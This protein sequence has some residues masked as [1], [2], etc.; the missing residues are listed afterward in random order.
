MIRVAFYE[1]AFARDPKNATL[2]W[3][4]LVEKL[5]SFRFSAKSLCS[6][7]PCTGRDSKGKL[8]AGKNGD[9]WS[10]VEI[11]GTRSNDNVR[12]VTVGVFDVDHPPDE[13]WIGRLEASGVEFVIHSTHQYPHEDRFRVA[14]PLSRKVSPDEWHQVHAAMMQALGLPADPLKDLSR[15]YFLPNAIEGVEPFS[16]HQPGHVLDVDKI[17]RPSPVTA[18][19]TAF[20]EPAPIDVN[21]LAASIRKHVKPENRMLV[22]RALRGEGLGPRARDGG[23]EYGG[24][25]NAL[26]ALMSTAAF[27]TDAAW[28]PIE[29]IFRPCFAATDWGE[30]FD[31]LIAVAK[32]K[33]ERARERKAKRDAQR[34]A[35][36]D[37]MWEA[38]GIIRAQRGERTTPLDE[39]VTDDP[40]RWGEKL[41]YTKE[42]TPKLA[43][44][45]ANVLRVLR[46]APEWKDAIRFNLVSKKLELRNA[47]DAI[48]SVDSLDVTIS[49]WFAES[50][51]GRLGLQPTPRMVGEALRAIPERMNY[52][53]LREYLDGLRW[54]GTKRI[55]TFL[56]HYFGAH[57]DPVEYLQAI[58]RRWLISLVAR[59][60]KPGTKVDTVLCLEGAQGLGKS[61]ALRALTEPWFCDTK[62]DISSKDSWSLAGQFW[63]M[64]LAEAEGMTRAQAEAL[65]GFFSKRDDTY[66]PPYG[67]TNATTLRRALFAVTTNAQQFLRFDPTGYRR[68]WPVTCG[69]LDIKG[70]KQDRDQ[71]LAEAVEAYRA[72]DLWYFFPD[73]AEGKLAET[74]ARKREESIGEASQDFIVE[75]LLSLPK[76]QRPKNVKV[77]ELLVHPNVFGLQRHQVTRMREM[78]VAEVLR[79]MGFTKYESWRGRAWKTP[80]ALLEAAQVQPIRGTPPTQQPSAQSATF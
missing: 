63:L 30:G 21:E 77:G 66:R 27:C 7:D 44:C 56:E 22:S 60:M 68:Y 20:P 74:A 55:D 35:E 54:D 69:A 12:A 52:D 59:G 50:P 13:S 80:D 23:N 25:D 40:D 41:I 57:G 64:E 75:W 18:T 17:A 42:K 47:P 9:A 67:R 3:I 53:P 34:Q 2:T 1:N 73:T 58:S 38:V 32:D 71:L 39:D 76:D 48:E 6:F 72:G 31:A 19:T 26:Q 28:E 43:V 11:E 33:F 45:E 29:H 79:A 24:Q 15:I 4:E 5:T 16:H 46:N 8:C 49:V 70:L 36:N 51:W 65:K 14:I 62:I 78:E 10:P 61:T 37:A